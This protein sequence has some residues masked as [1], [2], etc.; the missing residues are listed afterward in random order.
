MEQKE[1]EEGRRGAGEGVSGGFTGQAGVEILSS[2]RRGEGAESALVT[3]SWR[4]GGGSVC[5]SL[6]S[7]PALDRTLVHRRRE[8]L[9]KKTQ[10]SSILPVFNHLCSLFSNLKASHLKCARHQVHKPGV[11]F[12]DL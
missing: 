10:M 12:I 7:R 6:G 8:F 5:G 2:Q 4:G 11:A 1:Q 9:L 3:E